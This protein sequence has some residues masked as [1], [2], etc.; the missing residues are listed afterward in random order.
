MLC[1]LFEG[2]VLLG[3]AKVVADQD[4]VKQKEKSPRV[5]ENQKSLRQVKQKEK[6][7]WVN[8]T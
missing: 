6:S 4:R 1:D 3:E 5:K 2:E 8:K 7:H